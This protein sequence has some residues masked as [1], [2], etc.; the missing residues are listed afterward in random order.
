[1]RR[2]VHNPRRVV[3]RVATR[4]P[5]MRYERHVATGRRDERAIVRPD[6]NA[7]DPACAT[8][9]TG[10]SAGVTLDGCSASASSVS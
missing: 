9:G 6:D 2:M 5:P 8:S 3:V 1:M 7:A 10:G 4:G